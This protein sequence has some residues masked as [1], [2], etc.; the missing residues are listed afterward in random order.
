MLFDGTY[1]EIP[2]ARWQGRRARLQEAECQ[3][4]IGTLEEFG[5][6][7]RSSGYADGENVYRGREP[8]DGL[9]VV[10]KGALRVCERPTASRE[11]TTRMLGPWDIY[12]RFDPGGLDGHADGDHDPEEYDLL[13]SDP[14]TYAVSSGGCEVV[15]VPRVF[16][17]QVIQSRPEIVAP[18]LTLL[19]LRLSEQEEWRRCVS[20]RKTEERLAGLLPLLAEKFGGPRDQGRTGIRLRLT[21]REIAAMIATTRESVSVAL[22]RLSERGLVG[23]EDGCLVLPRPGW[24]LDTPEA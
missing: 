9:Y 21:Q 16:L 12:G 13:L 8:S 6:P 17:R 3:R 11:E 19:E 10:S 1:G 4:L 23:F 15:K 5:A 14:D 22:T 20:P 2:G 24:S 7:T 18:V